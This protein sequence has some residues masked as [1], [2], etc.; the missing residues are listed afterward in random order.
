M[1]YPDSYKEANLS[2]LVCKPGELCTILSDRKPNAQLKTVEREHLP[3]APSYVL[4]DRSHA[5]TRKHWTT[6]CAASIFLQQYKTSQVKPVWMV[7]YCYIFYFYWLL[8]NQAFCGRI[9]QSSPLAVKRKPEEGLESRRGN[10]ELSTCGWHRMT[11]D[12]TWLCH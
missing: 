12:L 10:G 11:A 6:L 7:F 1:Q 9:W 2:N 4:L 8:G 5:V 3:P